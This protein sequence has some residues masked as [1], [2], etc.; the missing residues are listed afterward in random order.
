MDGMPRSSCLFFACKGNRLGSE[1]AHGHKKHWNAVARDL[2]DSCRNHYALSHRNRGNRDGSC[3]A[4]SGHFD[5]DRQVV[6]RLKAAKEKTTAHSAV[7]T[8]PESIARSQCSDGR[9]DQQYN[10][11]KRNADLDH[12]QNL[13]PACEQRRVGWS[14]CGTL[15]ERDEQIIDKAWMPACTGKFGSLV[16]RNLHLWKEET[17]A[18][19]FPLFLTQGWAAAVQAPVPEREH[20]HVRQP[21]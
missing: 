19:E 9:R 18:A 21:K 14:E 10:D 5:F 1:P 6:N 13:C 7:T 16:M 17:L 8:H 3:G 12:C 2:S 15:R 4:H 20:D 11:A